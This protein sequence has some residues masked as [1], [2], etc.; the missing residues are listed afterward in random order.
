MISKCLVPTALSLVVFSG[1]AFAHPHHANEEARYSIFWKVPSQQ[2]GSVLAESQITQETSQY[3]F[4]STYQIVGET[5]TNRTIE[6]TKSSKSTKVS[7]F[8]R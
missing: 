1:L 6:V 2:S 5:L 7:E 4:V 3:G 8:A